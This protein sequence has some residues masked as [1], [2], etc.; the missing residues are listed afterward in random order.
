MCPGQ[1]AYLFVPAQ[2]T[3]NSGMLVYSHIYPV[4]CAANRYPGFKLTGR[5][6]ICQ[7]MTKVRI[8]Y[9]LFRK[10]AKIL[11]LIFIIE[12]IFQKFFFQILSL[13]FSFSMY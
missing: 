8:I 2:G 6:C 12:K 10:A 5:N 9:T 7:R 13:V 4:S 11:D 3:P 1:S